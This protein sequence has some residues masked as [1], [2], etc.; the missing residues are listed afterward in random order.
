MN[1]KLFSKILFSSTILALAYG[2]ASKGKG[3]TADKAEEDAKQTEIQADLAKKPPKWSSSGDSDIDLIGEKIWK[4]VDG[5]YTRMNQL[6]DK[7]NNQTDYNQ[8]LQTLAARQEEN[9]DFSAQDL[10][11]EWKA[12]TDGQAKQVPQVLAGARAVNNDLN[13]VEIFLKESLQLPEIVKIAVSV[14]SVKAKMESASFLTKAKLAKAALNLP[15]GV[16]YISHCNGVISKLKENN[17]VLL[18]TNKSQAN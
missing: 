11:N 7:V 3:G 12:D 2:C 18:A 8:F 1:I 4:L 6:N 14:K 16:A 15:K 13:A 5:S 10:I 17:K 9:K